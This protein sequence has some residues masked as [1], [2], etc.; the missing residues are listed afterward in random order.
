[1]N[2]TVSAEA[3]SVVSNPE[4]FCENPNHFVWS[5]AVLKTGR[6]QKVRFDNLPAPAHRIDRD[7][8]LSTRIRRHIAKMGYST[9]PP[10]LI[11]PGAR[12]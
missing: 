8:Y 4:E 10:A 11:A 1:M 3:L 9:R 2:R 7:N 6:G 12:A 5:W